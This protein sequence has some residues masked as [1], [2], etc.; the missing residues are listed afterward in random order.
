MLCEGIDYGIS[1]SQM[2]AV[3]IPSC[4]VRQKMVAFFFPLR[5]VT[6][7]FTAKLTSR[8]QVL[9]LRQWLQNTEHQR[10]H[11]AATSLDWALSSGQ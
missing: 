5:P 11:P 4:N 10:L 7:R 6:H 1:L 8:P 3:D 2:L 9:H